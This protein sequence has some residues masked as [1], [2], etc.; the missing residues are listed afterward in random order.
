[1]MKRATLRMIVVAV[2]A[3][4]AMAATPSAKADPTVYVAGSGNEFGTLDLTTGV[5][6]S[7]GTLNL[8][9]GDNIYGMGFGA[10]G[11][12]Y[13]FDSSLSDAHLFQINTSN[14]A[15]TDL[16][17]IGM[18]VIDA[19][20]DA[21]GT[22]YALEPGHEFRLLQ[23]QPAVDRDVGRRPHGCYE[24]GPHGGQRRRI[25]NL[26]DDDRPHNRHD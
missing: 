16:G 3:A 15:L 23:G 4:W 14:A 9:A 1:M 7:I 22:L 26:H 24:C 19:T 6:T 8:A 21:A 2:A 20:A 5:F 10:D 18:S 25:A 17:A 12:L 13:G 11:K